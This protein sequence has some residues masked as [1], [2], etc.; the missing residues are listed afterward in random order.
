[1]ITKHLKT[2]AALLLTLSTISPAATYTA[3]ASDPSN[4]TDLK[5]IRVHRPIFA[6]A[7]LRAGRDERLSVSVYINQGSARVIAVRAFAMD[8]SGKPTA[9]L[10]NLHDDGRDGD[11]YASDQR[12][13]TQLTLSERVPIVRSYAVAAE[14]EGL[15]QA[16]WSTTVSLETLPT[17]AP[18]GSAPPAFQR[19]VRD[20]V[21]ELDLACDGL[22]V[23]AAKG[24]AYAQI[25][26]AAAKVGAQIRGVSAMSDANAWNLAV[27]CMDFPALS[28]TIATLSADPS[29]ETVEAQPQLS[30]A[31]VP[32]NDPQIVTQAPDS[33]ARWAEILGHTRAWNL[34]KGTRFFNPMVA[35]L[36]TG[37]DYNN[38]ELM[39]RVTLGKDFV[40]INDFDPMDEQGHGTGT[41]ALVGAIANNAFGIVGGAPQARMLA[42]RVGNA[43]STIDHL[44][45]GIDYASANGA[46]I[47]NIS[48]GGGIRSRRLAAAIDQASAAGLLV[49]AAAG[50]FLK[51]KRFYPA[52]FEDSEYFGLNN[53]I[54]YHPHVLAVGAVETDGSLARFPSPIEPGSNYGSW[55]DISA[56]GLALVPIVADEFFHGGNGTSVSAPM[57]SAAAALVWSMDGALTGDAVREHLTASAQFT[58]HSDPAG[59]ALKRLNTFTAVLRAAARRCTSCFGVPTSSILPANFPSPGARISLGFAGAAPPPFALTDAQPSTINGVALPLLPRFVSVP[60]PAPSPFLQST[61]TISFSSNLR[62]FDS[63]N[64]QNG[65][66]DVFAMTLGSSYFNQT[67]S[68]DIRPLVNEYF[69]LGGAARLSSGLPAQLGTFTAQAITLT[70]STLPFLSVVLDTQT[71]PD[72]DLAKPSWGTVTL[73]DITPPSFE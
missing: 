19:L 58:G 13:S 62:T 22:L 26:A 38:V 47:L 63:Y 30:L 48:L 72:R 11:L 70:T 6:P 56:M 68:D 20:A 46:S 39:G 33:P 34:T 29:I 5:V 2:I 7:L 59:N 4:P 37:V 25:T 65:F 15:P 66:F 51:E 61:Y 35:I 27:P 44:A 67:L 45:D 36:D 16:L 57:V 52:A 42:I 3:A 64:A 1:M 43:L 18:V 73:E 17:D 10:A 31:G 50:N 69:A 71:L 14:I 53:R 54:V 28:N 41:A 12:Y 49:V 8:A 40:G 32:F 24:Q 23:Y 21:N 9:V 55:V 60:P